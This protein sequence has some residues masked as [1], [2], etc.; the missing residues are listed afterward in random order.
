MIKMAKR[1][2][3]IGKSQ[4]YGTTRLLGSYKTRK[5]AGTAEGFYMRDDDESDAGEISYRI[6]PVNVSS[7]NKKKG[8]RVSSHRRRKPRKR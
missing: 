7:Y 1:Y 4:K 2:I 3:L 6:K 8:K 5:E